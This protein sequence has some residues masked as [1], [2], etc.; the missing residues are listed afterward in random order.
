M[1]DHDE[2]FEEGNAAYHAG[3]ALSEG[4]PY[5]R[6]GLMWAAWREGWQWGKAHSDD[7]D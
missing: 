3:V 5:E 4:N 1:K 7:D 6:G 2:L